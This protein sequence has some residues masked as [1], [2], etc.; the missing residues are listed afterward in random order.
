MVTTI[1]ST[2]AFLNTNDKHFNS[3]SV[4]RHLNLHR[5]CLRCRQERTH[6]K[7][8]LATL[9]ITWKQLSQGCILHKEIHRLRCSPWHYQWPQASPKRRLMRTSSTST[10]LSRKTSSSPSFSP[11]PASSTGQVDPCLSGDDSRSPWMMK[12]AREPKIRTRSHCPSH[13]FHACPSNP[14]LTSSVLLDP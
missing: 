12:S 10:R 9:L 14:G 13:L 6:A 3:S 4:L 2:T 7:Y 11:S 8:M 1:S 5:R